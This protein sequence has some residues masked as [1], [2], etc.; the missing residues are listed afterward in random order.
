MRRVDLAAAQHLL[1]PF[2]RPFFGVKYLY[3]ITT[4]G[5]VNSLFYPA[6][7]FSHTIVCSLV[8]KCSVPPFPSLSPFISG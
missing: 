7:F 5:S 4:M 3:E 1:S 8:F 2:S 6:P